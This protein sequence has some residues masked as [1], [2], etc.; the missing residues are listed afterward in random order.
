MSPTIT[1]LALY[2][3][4]IIG[5]AYIGHELTYQYFRNQ[6]EK[7]SREFEAADSKSH[8][9]CKELRKQLSKFHTCRD[10]KGRFTKRV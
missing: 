2:V 4:G 5:G 6:T 10:E 1:T 7:L 9:I 8:F 3:I